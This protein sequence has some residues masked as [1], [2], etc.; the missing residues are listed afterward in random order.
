MITLTPKQ[1]VMMTL[2]AIVIGVTAGYF[3][4]FLLF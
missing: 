1:F 4:G 2:T 3:L